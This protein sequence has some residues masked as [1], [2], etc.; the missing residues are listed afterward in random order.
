MKNILLL[1]VNLFIVY[2]CSNEIVNENQKDKQQVLKDVSGQMNYSIAINKLN[3]SNNKVFPRSLTTSG[4]IFYV[5]QTDWTSGFYPGTLWLMYEL[6]VDKYWM[7]N[8]ANYTI[9][10][11]SEKFNNSDHDIGFKIMSSFGNGYRLTKNSEYRKVL[12]KA[13]RTLITRFNKN[14]GCIRSWDHHKEKWQ[15]PVIIDNMMNLELLFMAWKETGEPVFYNIAVK[16]AETTMKNHFRN[17]FSTY[18]VVSYDTLTGKVMAKN[19]YQ[20]FADESTWTRGQAWAL[21]GFTMVYRE[22]QKPEFLQQAQKIANYILNIGSL[23]EDYVPYWDFNVPQEKDE[24]RDVSAAAI[25]ASAFFELSTLSDTNK[26][27][28]INTANNIMS[29]LSSRG[30]LNKVGANQG[31]ILNHSTGSKPKGSEV[32]VPL[33]YADYYFLEAL[34]RKINLENN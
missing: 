11:E 27:I 3:K 6:T 10:L 9:L 34:K 20:G 22:T 13:A 1:L 30:Y 7:D 15:Y 16:H 28:Y 26:D 12:I 4:D 21:Y 31:F 23:P 33:I 24:P 29:S 5:A 14:V 25:M 19:T 17:D 8:A 2:S 32:D 18:H